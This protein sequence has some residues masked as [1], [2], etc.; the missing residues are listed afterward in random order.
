MIVAALCSPFVQP[1]AAAAAAAAPD[2]D[3]RGSSVEIVLLVLVF[4]RQK[5]LQ[6]HDGSGSCLQRVQQLEPQSLSLLDDPGG[7]QLRSAYY[8]NRGS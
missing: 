6:I 8:A 1:F 2:N 3:G 4:L 5:Q 7:L